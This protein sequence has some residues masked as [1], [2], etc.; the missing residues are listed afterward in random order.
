V[1]LMIAGPRF[2]E[3]RVLALASAYERATAWHSRKP[4]LQPGTP[5]PA[6]AVTDE[7]KE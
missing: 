3:G 6:L 7:D 5:V 2:S 4:P 1:G